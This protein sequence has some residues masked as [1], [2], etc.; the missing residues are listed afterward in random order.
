[1][2][3]MIMDPVA[4]NNAKKSDTPKN[5][6]KPKPNRYI[7]IVKRSDVSWKEALIKGFT[8]RL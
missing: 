5:T 4:K 1:M 8:G 6:T 3:N 2:T 7:K